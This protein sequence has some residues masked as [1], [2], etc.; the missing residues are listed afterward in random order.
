MA[1]EPTERELRSNV[2]GIHTRSRLLD[3]AL[4]SFAANGFHGTSTRDIAEAAG[5]SPSA[6]YA[7]YSTKEELL[8]RLSL[9]GHTEVRDLVVAAASASDDPVT[10]LRDIVTGFVAWHARFHTHARVVQYEMAA[11]SVGHREIIAALRHETQATLRQVLDD[12]VARG[13]FAIASSRTVARALSSLAI[14]VARWFEPSGSLTPEKIA[15]DYV[16]LAL[17]MVHHDGSPWPTAPSAPAGRLRD[18]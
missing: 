4:A 10:Q 8:F 11:L 15:S 5:M 13:L 1:T 14:D 6:V 16:E 2:R 3:A 12:G 7:H 18:N 17:G 9:S